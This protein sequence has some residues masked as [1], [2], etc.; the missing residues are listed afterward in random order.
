[1][2]VTKDVKA[3]TLLMVAKAFAFT[4]ADDFTDIFCAPNL[5]T[6][7]VDSPAQYINKIKVVQALRENPQRAKEFYALYAGEM[8]RDEEIPEGL[9]YSK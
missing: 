3:G 7:V 9:Q 6:G 8:R 4:V 2:V 1:M 5:L